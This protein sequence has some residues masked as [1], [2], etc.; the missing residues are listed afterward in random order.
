MQ[1]VGY[2]LFPRPFSH[3]CGG[4]HEPIVV[5]LGPADYIKALLKSRDLDSEE[6]YNFYFFVY[7]K[8]HS[9]RLVVVSIIN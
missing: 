8:P 1:V 7:T 2:A 5:L 3:G 9:D 6:I 4:Q